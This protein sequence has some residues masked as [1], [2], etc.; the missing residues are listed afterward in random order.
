MARE[1]HSGDRD[2]D[3]IG[4]CDRERREQD[5]QAP[6]PLEHCLEE[7]VPGIVVVVAVAG[8][9]RLA[10]HRDDG[11]DGAATPCGLI[12]E[13]LDLSQRRGDIDARVCLAGDQQVRLGDV[14]SRLAEQRRQPLSGGVAQAITWPSPPSTRIDDPLT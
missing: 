4:D 10:Q 8:E 9:A 12:R 11:V 6:P 3:A 7:R 1:P 13:E 14:R 2:A 5:R